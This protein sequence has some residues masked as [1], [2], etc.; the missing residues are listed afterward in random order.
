MPL[1][2]EAPKPLTWVVVHPEWGVY[3]GHALGMAFFSLH[4]VGSQPVAT[5]FE[6][7]S[8]AVDHITSWRNEGLDFAP[9]DFRFH[10]V[11]CEDRTFATP[12]EMAAAGIPDEMI[13]PF[14]KAELQNRETERELAQTMRLH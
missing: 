4:D 6:S 7:K 9:S 8:Q 10:D 11:A 5:T 2:P 12:D 3:A 14:R 13:E 1:D